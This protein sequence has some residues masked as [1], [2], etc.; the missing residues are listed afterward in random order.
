MFFINSP[1]TYVQYKFLHTWTLSTQH[2]LKWLVSVIMWLRL[3]WRFWKSSYIIITCPQ[4]PHSL[5]PHFFYVKELV[6]TN[7]DKKGSYYQNARTADSTCH[8]GHTQ[9]HNSSLIKKNILEQTLRFWWK[10]PPKVLIPTWHTPRS[11]AMFKE[12]LEALAVP[13]LRTDV[14]W[15]P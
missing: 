10:L 11:D 6:L 8:N 5:F 1:D 3:H 2:I 15:S 12:V 4:M 13:P 7:N 9:V 14:L